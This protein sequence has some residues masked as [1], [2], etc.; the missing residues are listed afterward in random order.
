MKKRCLSATWEP[1]GKCTLRPRTVPTVPG[2]A[3]ST[4][5]PGDS[6]TTSSLRSHTIPDF[7]NTSSRCQRQKQTHRNPSE[8]YP[9]HRACCRG[10]CTNGLPHSGN[11]TVPVGMASCR[12]GV[13]RPGQQV[14]ASPPSVF[15]PSHGQS[16]VCPWLLFC[17]DHNA[18][19]PTEPTALTTSL[20]GGS[21]VPSGSDE[22]S[23]WREKQQGDWWG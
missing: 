22:S 14:K 8:R 10:P 1:S 19:K 3:F 7:E 20:Y 21:V 16:R 4:Q 23:G 2:Y 9:R 5:P 6:F 17:H 18:E 12:H 15:P 11:H 13:F